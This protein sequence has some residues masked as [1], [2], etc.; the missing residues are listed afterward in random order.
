MD[1]QNFHVEVPDL[2]NVLHT[3][4]THGLLLHCHCS[5]TVV[6]PLGET[7]T[8]IVWFQNIP[9]IKRATVMKEFPLCVQY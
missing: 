4:L 6:E 8:T 5:S 1:G 2:G 9:L 7:I 3:L